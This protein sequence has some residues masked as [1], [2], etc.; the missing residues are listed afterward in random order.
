MS[1]R[2]F[3]RPVRWLL[4]KQ[5]IGGL[6]GILL[7][8]AYGEKLDPRDWMTGNCESFDDDQGEF[9]FD[10]LSDAGDGNRAMYSIAYLALSSLWTKLDA[11]TTVLPADEQSL[12]VTTIKESGFKFE[13]PRGQ[14]LF[15]GGDT[16]YHVA[17]YMTLINRFQRPFNYAYQDL[18]NR[19]L[20]SDTDP[21][22]PIFGIPGNH[23]YYDQIAGFRQQFRKPVRGEGPAPPPTGPYKSTPKSAALTVAGFER[24]QQASYVAIQLP[25]DWWFWG[26]D[27][28]PGLIDRRQKRFFTELPVNPADA[29]EA[30][31]EDKPALIPKK[32]IVA[33]CSPSTVFGRVAEAKDFKA[34][35]SMLALGLAV[36]FAP[37]TKEQP[38]PDL[39]ES[40]DDAL[41]EGQCRLDLSGD[42]HHYARYWGPATG[43][44]PRT[45]NSA[46][47]PAANSYASI[48]SGAG[49]AFHH[50]SS[51]YNNQVCEQV[52]YPDEGISRAAAAVTLFKFWNVLTG[53]YV[54][55][56]GFI[57]AFTIY[58]CI[59]APQSSKQFISNIGVVNK[60]DVTDSRKPVKIT[61]TIFHPL[62]KACAPVEP[63]APW[64]ALGVAG[65]NW[66]PQNCTSESP[67]YFFPDRKTW[68][69]DLI[70]GQVF[71][72]S[73]VILV[74]ITLILGLFTR[75]IFDNANPY[76]QGTN[77][78]KTLFPIIAITTPLIIIGLLS[79]QP[80]R[81]HI[82]PFISSLIVLF[83]IFVAFTA[84]ALNV[85]Y[86]EYL[87]K[88]SFVKKNDE[89]WSSW[90][91]GKVDAVLPWFLWIVAVIIVT[92]GLSFYGQNNIPAYLVS[93]IIFLVVLLASAVG[94]MVLPFKV[95]GSLLLTKPKWLQYV[96]KTAI[97]LWHLVL[98]LLVPYILIAN[99]NY[100]MWLFALILIVLPIW[101]AQW[102]LKKDYR[103]ALTLL[104]VLY[105]LAMLKLPW[106]TA[107]VLGLFHQNYTL[108]FLDVQ[109]WWVLIPAFIAGIIGA[110]ISC[111]WTGWY[112]AVCFAF[113][114]HNNEVGGTARIEEFKQFIRFRLTSKGL[115]GY[116]IAID[117]SG[118][119][120][121][122]DS[123]GRPLDG[124]DLKVKLIDVFHLVPKQATNEVPQRSTKSTN[125]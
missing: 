31:V 124:S 58:F 23:D 91:K 75:K 30:K 16:S 114:G 113:N 118:K 27:T 107:A 42:V 55:L 46:T 102:L 38:E 83:S 53:G 52:L 96:G 121:E 88:Q 47:Q 14:F 32:L 22:R 15:I 92:F 98:Q 63:F 49:G 36:P 110:I 123:T 108:V 125:S 8:A 20:I 85:R 5:L 37:T 64:K 40:G 13:L 81:Y 34:T 17:D 67:G 41:V 59:T 89:S 50:P 76:E 90:A 119:V 51:T 21:R 70:I 12:D 39:T 33:T 106:I 86:S 24:I 61:A 44:M 56:A 3:E 69:I 35:G 2:T 65:S 66:E 116:V 71:I 99:G 117:D 100:I 80:Y 72:W 94:I 1:E 115:T 48:V 4:G 68:P 79:V 18:R 9:W 74:A 103:I 45:H 11:Q 87:F 97:G 29:V 84:I 25:F 77:P 10:Y 101:P 60:L 28:E 78:D 120:G 6:K 62:S 109:G 54:W 122:K 57:M 19:N 26:L 43:N 112:F 95:A 111:L 93:D 105:G 7:Y 104:W 82:T 73:S